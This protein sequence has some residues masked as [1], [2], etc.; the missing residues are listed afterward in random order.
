[1]TMQRTENYLLFSFRQVNPNWRDSKT[2][3]TLT[4]PPSQAAKPERR[5]GAGF[6]G[7]LFASVDLFQ[8]RPKPAASRR[9]G[10]S[11]KLRPVRA[12]GVLPFAFPPLFSFSQLN[13]ETDRKSSDGSP[14]EKPD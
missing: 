11:V 5:L 4:L 1:M 2:G 3:R 13:Y 8:P 9:S 14:V 7:S 6:R 10:G 12:K